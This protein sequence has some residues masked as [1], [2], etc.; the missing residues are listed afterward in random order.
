MGTVFDIQIA[1]ENDILN[2]VKNNDGVILVS[3]NNNLPH[4]VL[5]VVKPL[6]TNPN[7]YLIGAQLYDETSLVPNSNK[8]IFLEK[9]NNQVNV[10]TFG[11]EMY[12]IM[13]ISGENIYG[14]IENDYL[15]MTQ[16]IT[17]AKKFIITKSIF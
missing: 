2:D 15:V 14:T 4:S 11:T 8:V 9:V 3:I 6:Q 12:L 16:D 1:T 10:I 17:K 13:N 5:S 7:K